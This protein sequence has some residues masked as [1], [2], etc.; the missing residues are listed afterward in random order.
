MLDLFFAAKITHLSAFS[1]NIG[2]KLLKR[3]YM[4]GY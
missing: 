3:G 1:K 4:F 2:Q